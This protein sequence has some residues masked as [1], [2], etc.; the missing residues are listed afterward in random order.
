MFVPGM[1]AAPWQ[2]LRLPSAV[3]ERLT[4]SAEVT[5]VAL[6]TSLTLPIARGCRS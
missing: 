2:A 3:A 5:L 6:M 4:G 1:F